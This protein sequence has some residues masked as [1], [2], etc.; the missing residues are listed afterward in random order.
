MP[1]KEPH[2]AFSGS[3]SLSKAID[4]IEKK[5]PQF[6][7]PGYQ[8]PAAGPEAEAFADRQ[9]L[10]ERLVGA[11]AAEWVMRAS[12][13]AHGEQSREKNLLNSL[14]L[15]PIDIE[16][17]PAPSAAPA[18]KR[19]LKA[20]RGEICQQVIKEVK[21]LHQRLLAKQVTPVSFEGLRKEH[22]NLTVLE[23]LAHP[24][25]DDEDR[26]LIWHPRQWGV[27]AVTYTTGILKKLFKVE[28]D[29]TI[30][31]YRKAYRRETRHRQ[32]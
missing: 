32:P 31:D 7:R 26:Y 4:R 14:G 9:F 15:K 17:R 16:P 5:Y 30:R 1:R 20:A 3:E 29:E 6:R 27:R 25:F 21:F 13:R 8:P 18:A 2:Q 28:S 23:I 22:P 12:A 19:S 11:V 10:Q 24:P